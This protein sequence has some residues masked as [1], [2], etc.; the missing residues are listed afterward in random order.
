MAITKASLIDLNGNE[1]ILDADADTTITADTDDQ[2]DIKVGG[3]DL[4]RID[5]SGLGVGIVPTEILDLKAASGDT[6]IRLD[7][8]SGSDTEIKFFNDGAAQFTIGHDDA[9]DTFRIGGANVDDPHFAWGKD[10]SLVVTCDAGGHTVFNENS[11]DADFRVETDGNSHML[12]IEGSTNRVGIGTDDPDV[13]LDVRNGSIMAGSASETIGSLTLQNYYS[14]DNHLATMGTNHS[15]GGWYFG[16]GVKQQGS[17][18]TQSTFSNF[19]GQRSF[20]QLFGDRMQFSFAAAQDTAI[21]TG[22]SNLSEKVRISE[23][24]VA[25]NGDTAA[26]NSL[27][28]YEEGTWTPG[29]NGTAFSTAVGSYTKIG[30]R[31]F[32]QFKVVQGS[33]GASSGDWTGLPFT[34]RNSTTLGVGGG[35]ASYHNENSSE[36]WAISTENVNS[37]TWTIRVGSQQ[38]QLSAGKQMWG[39]FS[40]LV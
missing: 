23:H 21:G 19:S 2:I 8:A 24:G 40:Y 14:G 26:A 37:T 38:K 16:Y 3:T 5:S 18:T 11:V 13:Q 22:V 12:F 1:M 36:V 7:A 29:N 20:A 10:G 15:S 9:S 25:F 35:N 17:G 27:D 31:V 39:F 4:I 6:R 28:D 33:G 32:C 34:I 30:D